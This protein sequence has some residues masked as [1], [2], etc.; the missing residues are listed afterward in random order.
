MSAISA[1]HAVCAPIAERHVCCFMR[2]PFS[3]SRFVSWACSHSPVCSS[4]FS[5]SFHSFSFFI[6]HRILTFFLTVQLLLCTTF[7]TFTAALRPWS[8][9]FVCDTRAT[10]CPYQQKTA[11]ISSRHT[12]MSMVYTSLFT[13]SLMTVPSRLF[14][15]CGFLSSST[16]TL[17]ACPTFLIEI[18]GF[19]TDLNGMESLICSP[20]AA[21][22]FFVVLGPVQFHFR[23]HLCQ[24]DMPCNSCVHCGSDVHPIVFDF[25]DFHNYFQHSAMTHGQ[26]SFTFNFDF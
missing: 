5:F 14:R 20:F 21:T 8:Y 6:G 10:H 15:M 3:C 4:C 22:K 16:T 26:T 18:N 12:H 1:R 13:S 7:L 9:K 24:H 23:E 25:N 11:P 17:P 2:F 19:T